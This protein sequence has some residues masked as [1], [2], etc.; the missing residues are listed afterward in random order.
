MTRFFAAVFLVLL[1]LV[2]GDSCNADG[3]GCKSN[4][5]CSRRTLTCQLKKDIGDTC[6]A[7]SKCFSGCCNDFKCGSCVTDYELIQLKVE[8]KKSSDCTIGDYCTGGKCM[9]ADSTQ[10]AVD[11]DCGETRGHSY[12]DI[13]RQCV[14]HCETN[15]DCPGEFFCDEQNKCNRKLV[16]GR[17]CR[18]DYQVR[19]FR[20]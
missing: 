14:R 1:P 12:C 8:C 17:Q 9:P 16:T 10:C 4:E 13:T 2:L 3:T 5:W 18:T 11:E 20:I 19:S 7:H 6:N 15:S